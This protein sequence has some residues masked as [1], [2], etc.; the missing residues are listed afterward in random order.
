[1][2]DFVAC[3]EHDVV[4]WSR[5]QTLHMWSINHSLRR[6]TIDSPNISFM[7]QSQSSLLF[8]IIDIFCHLWK[9]SVADYWM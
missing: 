5:D 9:I 8:E 3:S 7:C 6:V 2:H 1:L 4:A